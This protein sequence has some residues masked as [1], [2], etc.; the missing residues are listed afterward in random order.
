MENKILKLIR[1]ISAIAHFTGL[2]ALVLGAEALFL[3]PIMSWSF[4]LFLSSDNQIRESNSI[5][6]G[7]LEKTGSL[8][9][10]ALF[11]GSLLEASNLILG[12]RYYVGVPA[13]IWI[14][15]PFYLA[16]FAAIV[17]L[18]LEIE[19]KLDNMGLAE[20]LVWRKIRITRRLL[21]VFLAAG[22]LLLVPLAVLPSYFYPLFWIALLLL[23]DPLVHLLGHDE[24]SITGQ[25]EE[26]Y[27]GQA[28]RLIVAGICFG[29]LWEFW[30]F[31]AG[32]KW[33]YTQSGFDHA[34]LFEL[35][36]LE[37]WGYAFTALGAYAFYQLNLVLNE[38][39]LRVLSR[40]AALIMTI[41]GLILVLA[42]VMTG[43]DAVTAVS[44]RQVM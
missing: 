9:A 43:M 30:N 1:F 4:L 34:Y 7:S 19:R 42:A 14:R 15:W 40:K 18:I 44:F 6:L 25:F 10:A 22:L 13:E 23:T 11:F 3:L 35:P 12:H 36:I 26:S 27:Y 8:L 2:A 21:F 39:L 31:W 16:S 29:L 20:I 37:V 38:K 41:L 33:F 28:F 17:P 5:L 32:S 24:K